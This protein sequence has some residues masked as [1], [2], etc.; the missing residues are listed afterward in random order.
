MFVIK[1][2]AAGC[3]YQ[4]H[5]LSIVFHDSAEKQE[6]AKAG[7]NII[8]NVEMDVDVLFCEVSPADASS[9]RCAFIISRTRFKEDQKEHVVTLESVSNM[10]N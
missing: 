6:N 3:R 1:R 2:L 10:N 8:L 4:H 5:G 7:G 9:E